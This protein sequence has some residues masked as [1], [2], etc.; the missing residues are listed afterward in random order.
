MAT[1]VMTRFTT[2]GMHCHSCSMLIEMSVADIE[3]VESVAADNAA[4][5][6]DV[7]YDPDKVT[8]DMIIVEIV[9]AGYGAEVAQ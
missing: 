2:T 6:T 4:G 3:G 8:P 7:T 1:P 5:L 9:K